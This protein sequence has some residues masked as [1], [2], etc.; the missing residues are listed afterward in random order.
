MGPGRARAGWKATPPPW[1]QSRDS[2]EVIHAPSVGLGE[3]TPRILSYKH[4][5]ASQSSWKMCIRE[6][7]C[8]DFKNLLLQNKLIF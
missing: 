5:G 7:L 2:C 6:K 3:S 4:E 1:G 8:L